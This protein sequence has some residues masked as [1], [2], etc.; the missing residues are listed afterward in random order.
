MFLGLQLLLIVKIDKPLIAAMLRFRCN[1]LRQCVQMHE[2]CETSMKKQI[3]LLA[4]ESDALNIDVYC[5]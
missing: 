1:R 2:F 4:R 5:M 3:N